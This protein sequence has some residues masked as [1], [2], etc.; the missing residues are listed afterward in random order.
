MKPIR[1]E[2][3]GINSY[4]SRQVVDFERLTSKGLFGIFGKTGSGKSTI[5][6][7]ITLALYGN[8]PRGTREFINSNCKKA[9]VEYEF[10]IV[11]EGKRS[12]YIVKRRFKRNK[13]NKNAL[14]DYTMLQKRNDMGDYDI[15]EE[16]KVS[17]V[18]NR[19]KS[20]LGL[21]ESDF[22]R[23]VVLPQGKFSEF[24]TLTGKDRRNMLERIFS[25][26]EYGSKLSAKLRRKKSE[27]S[28]EIEVLQAR[29]NEYP[30][31]SSEKR[32]EL[33][34]NIKALK[35]DIEKIS[36][37]LENEKKKAE[38]NEAIY[39]LVIEKNE[40]EKNL[41][42]LKAKE[43]YI[44]S[45]L[46][47]V[48]RAEKA[49]TVV[50]EINKEEKL[51]LEI[52]NIEKEYENLK[53][54]YENKK[55][56][57][58]YK[59]EEYE[60]IKEKRD[61]I[62][63][64][65]DTR[66]SILNIISLK[67]KTLEKEKEVENLRKK[68]EKIEKEKKTLLE[69]KE[70]IS[71]KIEELYREKKEKNEKL[72]ES[73]ISS[74]YRELVK[75][76]IEIHRDIYRQENNIEKKNKKI[77]ELEEGNEGIKLTEKEKKII[78]DKL[79]EVSEEINSIVEAI[80]LQENIKTLND[81][82]FESLEAKISKME[83]KIFHLREDDK[84]IKELVESI[85]KEKS[86]V[87]ECILEKKKY[88]S[89]LEEK[90]EELEKFE[91][92]DE[93]NS[94]RRL[95]DEIKII[96]G[97][98]FHSGDIC[99]VCNNTVE[100]LEIQEHIGN[101]Y[102]KNKEKISSLKEEVT[103]ININIAKVETKMKNSQEKI[104]EY[105]KKKV[106]ISEKNSRENLK[107]LLKEKVQFETKIEREKAL[108]KSKKNEIERLKKEKE[109]SDK[110][111]SSLNNKKVKYDEYIRGIKNTIKII[112]DEIKG[113]EN[114][115]K[116]SLEELEEI[117]LKLINKLGED[118]LKKE[119][120]RQFFIDENKRVDESD[121]LSE[122]IS[123]Q[124][125]NI[126][127]EIE[128]KEKEDKKQAEEM[129]LFDSEIIKTKSEIDSLE[130]QGKDLREETL[131]KTNE[132]DFEKL[133]SIIEF[134]YD[135]FESLTGILDSFIRIVKAN[136]EEISKSYDILKK[137]I[138]ELEK[139][140]SSSK[141]K[142]DM[143]KEIAK[144]QN[145]N[146]DNMIERFDFKDRKE[147]S[148]YYMD[149]S[150]LLS[151]KEEIDKYKKEKAREEIVYGQLE[152][153]LAGKTISLEE[154]NKQLE[155]KKDLEEK[156]KEKNNIFVEEKYKISEMGKNLKLI[157]DIDEDL[158]KKTRLFD[159]IKEIDKLFEGNRFVEYLSQIYLNNIIIE[160]SER[161]SNMTNNRYSLEMNEN[162]LF[163]ISDNFN[164]GLRRAAD[165][166][167]GGEV[168]L[169]SLSLALALSSQIQL[170]GSAPL[171]FF[172]LDEGFGTLDSALL[173]TVMTSLENLK[174][175]NLSIGIISHVDEI[176]ARLPMKLEITMDESIQS[177][178]I[179]EVEE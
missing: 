9:S 132:I 158:K 157:K 34:E 102:E 141:V 31:I 92:I 77:K 93:E 112:T 53:A 169:T 131:E 85:N 76:G 137:E 21:E 89:I 168:F 49:N 75:K 78:E 72:K 167:S 175:D 134:K 35:E 97:K 65:S 104:D 57:L 8:I 79:S 114:D 90:N 2:I 16:G 125:E 144:E 153:K 22:L 15:I 67:E 106:L 91:K 12:R 178:I 29:L 74:E 130:K 166:L 95:S 173:D 100:K 10:E 109:N 83:E 45:T 39:K 87:S 44:N 71:K 124:L 170:K 145:K 136:F 26:E 99:P 84:Q 56:D 7:A 33:Q 123:H 54:D 150:I 52:E 128:V 63:Y 177:S 23:S 48:N 37:E 176:K 98:E 135:S 113:L 140:I 5:L 61:K 94:I 120:N 172:F 51:K 59:E 174:G 151:K 107:E 161:L 42:K 171:E 55:S 69:N 43:D 88:K 156:L 40:I 73:T 146:I 27:T 155:I 179:K 103:S 143:K 105:E 25:L 3:E 108:L 121:K 127:K 58:K 68:V 133:N 11:E 165:T 28:R 138:V 96:W 36:D 81:K 1:L 152:E 14:S 117:C 147:C 115:N 162:Y 4:S 70:K 116:K 86:I 19:I 142:L 101:E 66:K 126:S 47:A 50:P 148:L 30:N 160:A 118:I 159:N 154:K 163:V 110:K 20:I 13:D 41:E 80:A 129:A 119:D 164:G 62:E 60:E 6:D 149:E 46:E 111:S 38:E 24:L 32:D 139:N 122:E 17:E 64:I 18:N 82:E